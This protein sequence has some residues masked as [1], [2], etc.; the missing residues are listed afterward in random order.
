MGIRERSS[1]SRSTLTSASSLRSDGYY[2]ECRKDAQC[3]CNMC[4]ASITATLD[5]RQ[6]FKPSA[7]ENQPWPPPFP[8][9][10]PIPSSLSKKRGV[11][12]LNSFSYTS[13]RLR[14]LR[15][16]DRPFSLFIL[17]LIPLVLFFSVPCL[18]SFFSQTYFSYE[19]FESLAQASFARIRL[20]DQLDLIQRHV[21]RISRSSFVS[22]CTEHGD[23]SW[24][25][26][27]NGN[28]VHSKCVIYA[29]PVERISVWGSALM[30]GG[31]LGRSLVDRSFTVLS[32]RV[33]EWQ[34]GGLESI[35]HSQGS[36]WT[37][38]RWAASAVLLD[39]NTWILEYKRT[40]AS[41]GIGDLHVLKY[42]VV[43]AMKKVAYNVKLYY[44]TALFVRMKELDPLSNRGVSSDDRQTPT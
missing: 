39:S 44:D 15:F 43:S 13:P 14:K 34:E 11:H 23:V 30:T 32:G 40:L 38:R 25:L 16:R 9:S 42:L 1:P 18:I 8:C 27:E 37:M 12:T 26:A 33:V 6:P 5:L 19:S 29:S 41:T 28:L 36:S 24:R 20:V 35:T 3:E 4:K 21:S 7:K 31:I 2:L 17:L 10:S 22:N